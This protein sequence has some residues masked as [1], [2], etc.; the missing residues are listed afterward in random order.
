MGYPGNAKGIA[1][2]A[3]SAVRYGLAF[4]S[5]AIALCLARMFLHF[6]LR[7]TFI[8]FALSA[9][10][11]TFWYGGAKPGILAAVLASIVRIALR[12]ARQ[13]IPKAVG[14]MSPRI[15]KYD[16]AS[17]TTLLAF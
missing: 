15:P 8:A 11:V 5:V 16:C 13:R 6:H 9:I 7:Q 2:S 10:A 17:L 14:G 3:A 12:A 4:G 1:H